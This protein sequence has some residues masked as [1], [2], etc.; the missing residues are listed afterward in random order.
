M[1]VMD[2]WDISPLPAVAVVNLCRE[3]HVTVYEDLTEVQ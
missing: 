1:G 3:G 2:D